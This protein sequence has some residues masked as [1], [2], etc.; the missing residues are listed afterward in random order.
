MLYSTLLNLSNS[1]GSWSVMYTAAFSLLQQNK[2]STAVARNIDECTLGKV[3][4][5]GRQAGRSV[6]R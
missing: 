5:V 6:G 1:I 3:D 2:R 4:K